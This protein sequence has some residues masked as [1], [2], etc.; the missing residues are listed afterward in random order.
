M[1]GVMG[2]ADMKKKQVEESKMLKQKKESV[3]GEADDTSVEAT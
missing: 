2:D 1:K 3:S